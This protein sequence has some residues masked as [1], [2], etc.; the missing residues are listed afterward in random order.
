MVRASPAGNFSAAS[1]ALLIA[2]SSSGTGVTDRKV[3]AGVDVVGEKRRETD[4]FPR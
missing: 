1:T 4:F 2:Q 3:F